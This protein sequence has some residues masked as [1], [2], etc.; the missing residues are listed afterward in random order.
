VY[1]TITI[2]GCGLIG[3]SLALSI[4]KQYPNIKLYG[5]DPNYT[6][7]KDIPQA[8]CFSLLSDTINDIPQDTELVIVAT[9]IHVTID[10]IKKVSMQ[11]S[12]QC[13]ISDVTSTK[14]ALLSE[15]NTLDLKQ[16]Y[17]S[18][19]PMAGKETTGF[20]VASDTLFTNAPYI[21]IDNLFVAEHKKLS[22]FLTSLSCNVTTCSKEVHDDLIALVS[23]LPYLTATALMQVATQ[24]HTLETIQTIFGPGFKDSTR[25][26]SSAPQWGID[27]CNQNKSNIIAAVETTIKAL[28]DI[29]TMIQ[30]NQTSDLTR[31][32]NESKQ[33]RDRLTS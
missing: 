29:K 2:I 14:E 23:H 26:A 27:V 25:L 21:L 30:E 11:V 32:L 10:T 13:L 8:S 1:S 24:T 12:Q 28:S 17:I 22:E 18:G 6:T 4:H 16:P 9:P 5:I 7:I 15:I 31:Y 20:D 19:H 33:K 3:G